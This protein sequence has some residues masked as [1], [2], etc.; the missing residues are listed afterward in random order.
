MPSCARVATVPSTSETARPIA[1]KTFGW[2]IDSSSYEESVSTEIV[3]AHGD[4]LEAL[5]S[6]RR[7]KRY[8]VAD[9]CGQQ[10][11]RQ[12]R[13]PRHAR[14]AGVELVHADDCD[15]AFVAGLAEERDGRAE[16]DPF[17]GL[18]GVVHH[19]G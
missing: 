15:D 16:A 1:A 10:R 3:I 13:T 12:W 17:V 19:D 7:A 2:V 4:D 9:L 8:R 6:S 11:P 5:R 18:A 14:I